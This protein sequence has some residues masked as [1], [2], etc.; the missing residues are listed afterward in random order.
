MLFNKK[1]LRAALAGS[2]VV[3]LILFTTG[4]DS[5]SPTTETA[6]LS[7]SFKLASGLAKT[8]AAIEITEAKILVRELEFELVGD[9]ADDGLD[10]DSTKL[11]IEDDEIDDRDDEFKTGMFVVN[12]DPAS[13]VT[14][15]VQGD[16]PYG[17]YDEIEFDIHK[18]EDT[19]A[20]PDDEFRDGSSGNE[21]YS[22]I[23]RGSKDGQPFEL[24]ISESM[25]QEIEMNTPLV[26]DEFT[27]DASV[28]IT[29]DVNSWFVGENGVEL[30]PTSPDDFPAIVNAIKNSFEGY[31]S[32]DDDDDD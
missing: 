18:P 4:C 5:N 29:V 15:I 27:T 6:Q 2:L 22:V 10:S 14:N 23:L 13:T 31:E 7:L 25:E 11:D 21:R 3:F 16:I 9:D 24:K 12:L 17:T 28:D 20:I 26:I 30:D 19:E 1:S 8:S 32:P